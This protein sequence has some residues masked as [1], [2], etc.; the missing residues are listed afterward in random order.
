M[1]EAKGVLRAGGQKE[2]FVSQIV[3]PQNPVYLYGA[4]DK[5]GVAAQD[6]SSTQPIIGVA[7]SVSGYKVHTESTLKS[8]SHLH[9]LTRSG[10][11]S[12][13]CPKLAS[14]LSLIHK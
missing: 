7:C 11:I 4:V 10:S 12:G 8:L 3:T 13:L 14:L 6:A 2:R 1:E 5:K 9:S